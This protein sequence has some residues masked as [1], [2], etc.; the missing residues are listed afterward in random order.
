MSGGSAE[1]RRKN[2]AVGNSVA[3]FVNP[4]HPEQVVLSRQMSWANWVLPFIFLGLGVWLGYATRKTILW[5]SQQ[6]ESR[7]SSILDPVTT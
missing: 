2:Y 7:L 4:N 6:A 3:C 5:G 1:A